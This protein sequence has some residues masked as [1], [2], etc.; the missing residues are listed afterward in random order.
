MGGSPE[1]DSGKQVL[2]LNTGSLEKG[3]AGWGGDQG[4][5]TGSWKGPGAGGTAGRWVGTRGHGQ[6][7]QEGPGKNP[8]A[9][10]LRAHGPR[11]LPQTR[12][13]RS[14]PE[15]EGQC[16]VWLHS[17]G[18]AGGQGPD[19]LL[20][21]A[22]RSRC[23]AHGAAGLLLP[24][25]PF[26]LMSFPESPAVPS[27]TPT[28]SPP[29]SRDSDPAPSPAV[30]LHQRPLPSLP[31][32]PSS[33][34]SGCVCVS[35]PMTHRGTCSQ[36]SGPSQPLGCVPEALSFPWRVCPVSRPE[37]LELPG[38]AVPTKSGG[39]APASGQPARPQS[40]SK[41]QA[42]AGSG[43]TEMSEGSVLLG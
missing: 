34:C 25:I 11:P 43:C 17:G 39:R 42:A 33:S 13:L 16:L 3:E 8:S 9:W 21:A 23:S 32:S 36:S 20:G 30:L 24:L 1:R 12:A 31:R 10:P 37:E 28:F 15:A 4:L 40:H 5:G 2:L 38:P 6:E 7:Q 19:V 18:E 14:H 29:P 41:R 26:L 22:P 27:P 35:G